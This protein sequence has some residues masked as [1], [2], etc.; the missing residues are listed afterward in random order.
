MVTRLVSFDVN[1]SPTF[2]GYPGKLNFAPRIQAL[3]TFQFSPWTA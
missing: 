3:G 1:Q 2:I